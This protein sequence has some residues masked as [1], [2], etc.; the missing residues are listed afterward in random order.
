[1]QKLV[2]FGDLQLL[3]RYALRFAP[4]QRA[5]K[6]EYLLDRVDD[7]QS[8]V[9]ITGHVHPLY[10]D[11]SISA[12]ALRLGGSKLTAD[13]NIDVLQ[14]FATVLSEVTDFVCADK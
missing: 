5:S 10:G 4:E 6:C 2:T 14:A 7:A 9:T 11:G 8:F 3:T 12:L 13:L 1:M